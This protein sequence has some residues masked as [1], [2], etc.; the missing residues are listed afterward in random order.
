MKKLQDV[1][2]SLKETVAEL[3]AENLDL[4]KK[5]SKMKDL[6]LQYE[7]NRVKHFNETEEIIKQLTLENLNLR[8]VLTIGKEN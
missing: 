7:A 8:K 6:V 3:S 5:F 2:K 1:N 4:V